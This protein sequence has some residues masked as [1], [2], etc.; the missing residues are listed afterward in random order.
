L[1]FRH[2]AL[3]GQI[4]LVEGLFDRLTDIGPVQTMVLSTG[5]S[6]SRIGGGTKRIAFADHLLL[7]TR[8][9]RRIDEGRNAATPARSIIASKM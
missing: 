2:F 8:Q 1:V 9:C 6:T 7:L 5:D 4:D 3:V